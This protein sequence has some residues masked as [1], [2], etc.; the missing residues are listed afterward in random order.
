MKSEI[1]AT[2]SWSTASFGTE[3]HTS[4]MELRA[5]N[6]HLQH[7]NAAHGM[8]FRLRCA[9]EALNGF[10]STRLM[11]SLALVA[12]PVLLLSLFL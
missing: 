3:V 11:T 9:A 2:P 8:V 4:P 6:E 7:C 12:L 1:F 5:L 10:V